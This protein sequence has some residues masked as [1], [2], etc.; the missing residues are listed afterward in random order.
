MKKRFLTR[1]LSHS[2]LSSFEYSPD[3]WYDSYILDIKTPPTEEMK[4]GNRIGDAIGTDQ[5]PIPDLTP[6]GVKEYELRA[7]WEDIPL[8][9]FADHYCP[10]TN[11]LH[12]NKT[13]ANRQR[14][15]QSKVDQHHQ[16]TMY[17]MLLELQHGIEPESV[18]MYLNFIPVRLIG[19]TY[20]P[21]GTW[22]QF[23]TKRTRADVE[24]Y[25]VYLLDKIDQMERYLQLRK[26]STPARRPPAF[27]GV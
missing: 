9:G 26:L 16:L 19:L 14:W 7:T 18:E 3:Q 15:T 12:E 1:P 23:P 25:K 8:V 24:A 10:D 4:A 27:S 20:Q 17:A 5:S 21:E 6:P 11:I 2:Q 22:R 13:S